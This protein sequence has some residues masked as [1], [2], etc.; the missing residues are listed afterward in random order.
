MNASQ[1]LHFK[2]LESLFLLYFF[3]SVILNFIKICSV[4]S[5]RRTCL[6]FVKYLHDF[7]WEPLRVNE[8]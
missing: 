6:I 1:N 8:A 3:V 7:P 4:Q 5:N 2:N